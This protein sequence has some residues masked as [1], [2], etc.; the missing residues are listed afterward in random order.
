MHRRIP[1]LHQC[2]EH[3]IH[4]TVFLSPDCETQSQPA[5]SFGDSHFSSRSHQP[6]DGNLSVPSLPPRPIFGLLRSN[7]TGID[8]PDANIVDSEAKK[9]RRQRN[10]AAARKYRQRRLDRIEELE[11]ALRETQTERDELKVQVA[12]WKGKAEAL[13]VMM[14]NS[15][16]GNG[17]KQSWSLA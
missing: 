7:P 13:Q 10:S 15:G 5:A 1:S 16:T 12:R 11:Q 8:L 4:P 3:R 14:V 2:A 6:D 17:K 9:V